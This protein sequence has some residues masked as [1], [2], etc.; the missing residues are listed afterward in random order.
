V[1]A[2]DVRARYRVPAALS[3]RIKVRGELGTI[4]GFEGAR[5]LVL[6]DGQKSL[7]TVHPVVGVVYPPPGKVFPPVSRSPRR[8][9]LSLAPEEPPA[10]RNPGRSARV[11]S[12]MELGLEP[13]PVDDPRHGTVDGY[14]K[15]KC[16][17]N[18]CRAAWRA[19][20]KEFK[21]ARVAQALDPN[22]PR[23]GTPNFYS[24]YDCR[25]RP[26]TDAM[27]AIDPRVKGKGTL[28][29]RPTTRRPRPGEIE[30][31]LQ[32]AHS[33]VTGIQDHEMAS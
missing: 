29:S 33:H 15:Y 17:C 11:K 3:M 26:C 1:S 12:D 32:A 9:H 19:R 13:L 10:R 2:Q 18:P 22:D 5:L 24:N 14:R 23:H 31:K 21:A 4:A 30:V 6:M 28:G 25:C 27:N 7:A 8:S 20:C 16:K